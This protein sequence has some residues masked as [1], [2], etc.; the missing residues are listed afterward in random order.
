MKVISKQ[1]IEAIERFVI[2]PIY[3]ILVA[4]GNLRFANNVNNLCNSIYFSCFS[5][6][7]IARMINRP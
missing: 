6:Y 3:A 7:S 4:N 5:F 1:I 2:G